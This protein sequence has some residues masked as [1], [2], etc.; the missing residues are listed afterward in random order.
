[1]HITIAAALAITCAFAGVEAG[2]PPA[3][4]TPPVYLNPDCDVGAR[5]RDLV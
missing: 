1:M 2:G 5:G 3:P 4:Q